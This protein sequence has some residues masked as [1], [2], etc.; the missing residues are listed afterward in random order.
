MAAYFFDSSALLKRWLREPGAGR[1]RELTARRAAHDL[2]AARLAL[3]EI[4]G[5]LARRHRA[6]DISDADRARLFHAVRRD[7]RT[8]LML[9]AVPLA[10]WAR[11]GDLAERH[12]LRGADA[13]HV[14]VALR[15]RQVHLAQRTEDM[16]F[17]TSDREQGVAALAEGLAVETPTDP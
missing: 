15:V 3:P 9:I 6:A 12:C 1:V 4:L 16:I 10:T 17:V 14:A 13:V 2:Y 5:A 7:L 8:R 11:A